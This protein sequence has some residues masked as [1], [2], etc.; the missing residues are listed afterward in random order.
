[1]FFFF[2]D[3][4]NPIAKNEGYTWKMKGESQGERPFFFSGAFAT[5]EY[6]ICENFLN[7]GPGSAYFYN[8]F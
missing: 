2:Y 7:V 4:I 3:M 8:D 1:M 6:V 5:A